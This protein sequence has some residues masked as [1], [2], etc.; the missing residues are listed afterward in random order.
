MIAR[1]DDAVELLHDSR[2]TTGD[3]GPDGQVSETRVRLPPHLRELQQIFKMMMPG[4]DGGDHARLRKSI[5]GVFTRLRVERLRAH[6]REIIE[7][8]LW[9]KDGGRELELISV[10]ARPLPVIVMAELL[11]A[12]KDDRHELMILADDASAIADRT[13]RP[14]GAEGYAHPERMRHFGRI[15][16]SARALVRYFRQ[17]VRERRAEPRDDLVSALIAT[18]RQPDGLT[19]EEII[20]MC[21]VLLGAGQ[22]TTR[23]VIGN[24]ML[25]LLR[26]PEQKERLVAEPEQ[27][28]RAIEEMLRY[29]PPIQM[30]FRVAVEDVEYQGF[31][32]RRGEEVNILIGAANRDP[33]HFPD[34]D[35]FDLTR[36]NLRHVAFGAGPHY[37]LGAHLFQ[38]ETELTFVTLL[39]RSPG[40]SLASDVVERRPGHVFRGLKTLPLRL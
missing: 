22:G 18:Q 2:F 3:V 21:I 9:N 16:H 34:P 36:R 17:L 37:C 32:I 26:H 39:A 24:G 6:I 20:A 11:G 40:I 35:H 28:P 19:D 1:Y 33:D 14:F 29:D 5:S 23:D 10:V 8:L 12:A 13:V 38:V 7:E 4:R 31:H 30:A 15:L 25:A 27:I